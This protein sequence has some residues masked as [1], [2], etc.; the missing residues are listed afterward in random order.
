MARL[1]GTSTALL[2]FPGIRDYPAPGARRG[3][4]MSIR[5]KSPP[6]KCWQRATTA[7]YSVAFVFQPRYLSSLPSLLSS[8]R[9]KQRTNTSGFA[10]FLVQDEVVSKIVGA[11]AEALPSARSLPKRRAVN[12]EAYDVFIRG[13]SLA[14]QVQDAKAA[15]PLLSK[16][17]ELDPDFAEAHAWL[18]MTHLVG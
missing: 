3:Q 2:R 12:L 14:T 6:C 17:I 18:A 4:M 11:F 7:G 5:R 16:A 15:R 9:M 8:S 1:S 10:L 13:R